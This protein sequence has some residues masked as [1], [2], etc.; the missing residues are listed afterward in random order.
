MK[1]EL[2]WITPAAEAT[3]V[4]MARV[5]N[6]ASAQAGKGNDQLIR[7]L[8]KHKHW[9]PFEMV[10]ACFDI[11]TTR[12]IARQILRHRSFSF[13]EFSQRY[14]DPGKEMEF[15]LRSA[16]MQDPKNRQSSIRNEDGLLEEMWVEQQK[17]AL[18]ESMNAY[19]WAIS[20]GIAK[21]IARNVLPEGM[22]PS[23][24]YMVGS[25]RS[26]MHYL[27]IRMDPDTQFEH[28]VL[29]ES[30]YNTLVNHA[31]TVFIHGVHECRSN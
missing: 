4:R 24:L 11:E 17:A 7:Y 20:Q 22:T 27:A 6:P 31:P 14:A 3:L 18:R 13:Q 12:D 9:S 26:W 30:I 2:E 23:K 25:F 28:R 29:A 16:R 21:E 19:Q 8:I 15:Q 1:V 5:S 10:H